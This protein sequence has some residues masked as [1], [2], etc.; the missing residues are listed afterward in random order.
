MCIIASFLP[1][2]V[3]GNA[4][5]G[6]IRSRLYVAGAAPSDSGVYSCWYD[7]ATSDSVTVH[8]LDGA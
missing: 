1:R 8:V 4:A 7:N 2:S 5:A 3:K 6:F